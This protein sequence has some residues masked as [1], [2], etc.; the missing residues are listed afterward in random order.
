[1][2]LTSTSNVAV[3]ALEHSTAKHNSAISASWV[4]VSSY[5]VFYHALIVNMCLYHYLDSAKVLHSLINN[6]IALLKVLLTTILPNLV[7]YGFVRALNGPLICKIYE[8]LHLLVLCDNQTNCDN[9]I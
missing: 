9:R 7:A 1:M 4:I 8:L 3:E 5:S 6:V 2:L